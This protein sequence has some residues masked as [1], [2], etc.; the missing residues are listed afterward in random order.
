MASVAC[1][2]LAPLTVNVAACP[3]LTFADA[4]LTLAI[5][6]FELLTAIGPM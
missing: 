3:P 6:E 1:P 4:G 2:A 5:P